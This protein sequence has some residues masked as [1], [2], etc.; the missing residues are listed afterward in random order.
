[1]VP[2]RLFCPAGIVPKDL[3]SRRGCRIP[4]QM[5]PSLRS[6]KSMFSPFGLPI[7]WSNH[8]VVTN[9]FCQRQAQYLSSMRSTSAGATGP[10]RGTRMSSYVDLKVRRCGPFR[11]T[12]KITGE[13]ADEVDGRCR[14]VNSRSGGSQA[15]AKSPSY[16]PLEGSVEGRCGAPDQLS[17]HQPWGLLELR[18]KFIWSPNFSDFSSRGYEQIISDWARISLHCF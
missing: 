1:M 16:G 3:G 5:C 4:L 8:K 18:M 9:P 13:I 6:R 2:G 14:G 17:S 15:N 7:R 11:P 10:R 12:G